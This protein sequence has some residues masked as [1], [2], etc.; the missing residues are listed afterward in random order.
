MPHTSCSFGGGADVLD[1]DAVELRERGLRAGVE[2]AAARRDHDALQE[3]AEVEPAALAAC[4]RSI[5]NIRPTGAP[6][7]S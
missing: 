4:T 6:K 2:A 5:V 3:H 1:D 7:K